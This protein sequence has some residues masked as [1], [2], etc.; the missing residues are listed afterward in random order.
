M[1]GVAKGLPTIISGEAGCQGEY[2]TCTLRS[3]VSA[4]TTLSQAPQF[5]FLR[6]SSSKRDLAASLY[7]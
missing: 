2:P 3:S 5:G 6:I 7:L 4:H 1:R